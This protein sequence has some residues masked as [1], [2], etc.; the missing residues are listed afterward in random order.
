MNM[1][2]LKKEKPTV[3]EYN[4]SNL[5]YDSRY[6]FYDHYNKT[7][8]KKKK[9]NS[10]HDNALGLYNEFLEIYFDQ[11]MALSDAKRKSWVINMILLIYF[12]KHIAMITGLKVKN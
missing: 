6:S 10:L 12:L 8:K 1:K 4:R 5:V 2:E 3:K 11:Y 7:H 9:K